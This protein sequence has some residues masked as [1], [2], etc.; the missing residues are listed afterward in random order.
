MELAYNMTDRDSK[1]L[2]RRTAS[3]KVLPDKAFNIVKNPKYGGYQQGLP[4]LFMIFFI[5]H[6]LLVLLHMNG[7]R[8]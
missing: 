3:D 8:P 6:F 4:S 1:D 5:K 2:S 7:Q